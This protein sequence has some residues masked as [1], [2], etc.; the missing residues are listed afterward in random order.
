[1]MDFELELQRRLD[2]KTKPLGALGRMEGLA[3][4]LARVTGSLGPQ[5]ERCRLIIFA[6]DHGIAAE[7]VSAYP[8]A[9]TRQMLL[10]FLNGG[11][12]ANVFARAAGVELRVVDAGVA[13]EPIL[14]QDLLSHRIGPGTANSRHGAAM[15]E[16]Q[17]DQAKLQLEMMRLRME[18]DRKRD[19]TN[20]RAT[21]DLAKADMA[22]AASLSAETIRQMNRPG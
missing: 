7:G 20:V 22:G 12:A 8:Q 6:G 14:H 19:E 2:A 10:N 11:A 5:L 3:A 9:V 13:D 15:T 21:V 17:R 18:D 16:A 4:D 1:M